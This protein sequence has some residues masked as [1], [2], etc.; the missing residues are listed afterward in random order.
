MATPAEERWCFPRLWCPVCQRGA[1]T[2]EDLIDHQL[3]RRHWRAISPP[4]PAQAQQL[5]DAL[6]AAE[7]RQ[8][9]EAHADDKPLSL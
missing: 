3:H 2:L 7:A 9:E 1:T 4:D 6:E 5:M 8:R